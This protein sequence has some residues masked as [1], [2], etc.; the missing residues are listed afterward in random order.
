[1]I[2][3]GIYKYTSP[4]GKIYIGSSKNI[5]KRIVHYKSESCKNQTKLY[6]SF[7]KYG[8]EN[9]KFEIIEECLFEDLYLKERY[10]GELFNVL[11]NNGLNLI[12]PKIGENKIGISEET[13]L[14]MSESKKGDKN[15]FYGKKHSEETKEKISNSHKGK[16]HTEEHRRKVSENNAKNMSKTVLDLNTGVFYNS[17][18]EV[19]DLYNLNHSTLRSQLNGTN[20]NN[21]QF[22]YI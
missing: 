6:N 13:R 16:K 9:H 18:K 22:V 1:M 12:L 10:Y 20:K 19:S 4:S 17:A 8:Y 2:I 11:N 14:K 3:C 15:I 5:N 7:K 21:T